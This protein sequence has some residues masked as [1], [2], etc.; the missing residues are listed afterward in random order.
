MINELFDIILDRKRNQPRGSYTAQLLQEGQD[1]ILKKVG[2]ETMEVILAATGQGK[3]RVIEET[4]DLLY[5]TLVLLAYQD[6]SFDEVQRELR[7]RHLK[8]GS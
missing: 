2:E 1:S 6:I 5:H 4:A 8:Q 7:Q 3:Q